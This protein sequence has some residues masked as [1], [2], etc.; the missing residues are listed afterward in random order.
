MKWNKHITNTR[1][2][3][4]DRASICIST[5]PKLGQ[6]AVKC[7]IIFP[8]QANTLDYKPPCSAYIQERVPRL[9]HLL[10]FVD[11][12]IS[13]MFLMQIQTCRPQGDLYAQLFAK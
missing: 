3:L 8:E 13:A 4:S 11:R 10:Y 5:P 1:V 2:I 7:I 9:F 12:R 6:P